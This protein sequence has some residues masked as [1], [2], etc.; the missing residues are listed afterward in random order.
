MNVPNTA[1]TGRS[2]TDVYGAIV[3]AVDDAVRLANGL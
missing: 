3:K 2:F 1:E